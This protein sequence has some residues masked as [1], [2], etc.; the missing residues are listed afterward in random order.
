M[1]TI[2]L[3]LLATLSGFAEIRELPGGN[4]VPHDQYLRVVSESESPVER[5]YIK[6]NDGVY[7][8]AAIRKPP[9][10]GPFPTFIQFHG[11][12]GGQGME[13]L[14]SWIR[15]ETGGPMWERYLQEG[16]VV[17]AADYRG[18]ARGRPGAENPEGAVTRYDDGLAV[19]EH[20]RSLPYVDGNRISLYGGSFGGDL[21]LHL[22]TRTKV[23]AAGVGA[24][25]AFWFLG[26]DP[27]TGARRTPEYWK[28]LKFDMELAKRRI[29]A[30]QCPLLIQ[31]GSIDSLINLSRPI[32]DLMEETGKPVRMEI[33][34]D[35]PHGFYFGRLRTYGD[36][37]VLDSTLGALNSAVAFM[38][39]HTR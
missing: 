18:G 14:I 27:E 37:S 4:A 30:I 17:V 16:F 2:F 32:H 12:P 7:V 24:P 33:Y 25:A 11:A 28:N 35:S 26:V 29:A 34:A 15:G 23:R 21:V 20:V 19:I 38:K 22:I 31:V 3:C 36:R 5:A 6:S 9:G 8:A 10:K 39:E 1:R 13:T